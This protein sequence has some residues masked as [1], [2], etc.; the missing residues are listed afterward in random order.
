[1]DYQEFDQKKISGF[2]ETQLPDFIRSQFTLNNGKTL[3]QRF[4]ELYYEWLE[5]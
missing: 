3:I 4:I 1:M 2:I 5:K